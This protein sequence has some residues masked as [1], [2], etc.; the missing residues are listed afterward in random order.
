MHT[1]LVIDDDQ[2]TLTMFRL[3][4]QACGYQ[5]LVAADGQTGLGLLE[6]VATARGHP[7]PSTSQ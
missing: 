3:F 6:K 7:M 4:M 1:V 5:V 2:A